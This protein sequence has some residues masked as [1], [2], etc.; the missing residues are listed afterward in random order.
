VS[1][2]ENEYKLPT[3][4]GIN[5]VWRVQEQ[6]L[7]NVFGYAAIINTKYSSDIRESLLNIKKLLRQIYRCYDFYRKLYNSYKHGYRLWFAHDHKNQI[8]I[9]VYIPTLRGKHIRK[10]RK[11]MP[12]DEGSLSLVLDCSRY[13]KQL[14]D[15]LIENE[16]QLLAVRKKRR[17]NNNIELSF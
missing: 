4:G 2:I 9:I 17:S 3:K 13:C 10:Q 14:F 15:I 12:T 1:Q 7:K 5:R 16:R 11:Y 8:D 6:S